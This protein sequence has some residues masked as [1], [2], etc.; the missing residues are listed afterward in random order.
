MG[1]LNYI[2]YTIHVPKK[3]RK[4]TIKNSRI[5]AV[6]VIVMSGAV[7]RDVTGPGRYRRLCNTNYYVTSWDLQRCT[8]RQQLSCLKRGYILLESKVWAFFTN[9]SATFA[10]N[11]GPSTENY[12][13]T[14]ERTEDESRTSIFEISWIPSQILRSSD[15]GL[16][17]EKERCSLCR[18][19]VTGAACSPWHSS[20]I[21]MAIGEPPWRFSSKG[22]ASGYSDYLGLPILW[23]LYRYIVVKTLLFLPFSPA[24]AL[25]LR[26]P[27]SCNSTPTPMA[28]RHLFDI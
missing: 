23:P 7:W 16:E 28:E 9:T 14:S 10:K 4:K 6:S 2:P 20:N 26:F 8:T 24:S 13:H 22:R 1:F 25:F 17:C 15:L 18:L 11:M 21:R 27:I 12:V 5:S 19:Y 3:K